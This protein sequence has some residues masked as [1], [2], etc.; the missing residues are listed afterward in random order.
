VHIL[1]IDGT[2]FIGPH[3]VWRLSATDHEVTVLHRGQTEPELPPEVRHLQGRRRYFTIGKRTHRESEQRKT[4]TQDRRRDASIE[5]VAS[6]Q[7]VRGGSDA[8]V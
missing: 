4:A 2:G 5:G 7:V 6:G 1:I 3:V 8:A